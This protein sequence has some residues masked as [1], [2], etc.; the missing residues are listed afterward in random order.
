MTAQMG[1]DFVIVDCE[2]GDIA[3]A[4]MHQS[5]AAIA[6]QGVS[7]VV[8]IAAPE[9][10]L[11]KRALD[12]GGWSSHLAPSISRC[13]INTNSSCTLVSHDVYS[14]M[15]FLIAAIF[16]R[17]SH[18]IQE[19]ARAFVSYTKFPEPLA[20]RRP[21]VISGVRGVGS[22]FAPAA[23]GQSQAEYTATANKNVFIAVQIETV[24]GLNNCE[25]IAKVDGI[26]KS[27]QGLKAPHRFDV[28]CRHVVYRVGTKY[29]NRTVFDS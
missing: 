18:F 25:E 23:L 15:V 24:E 9:N 29:L 8:R 21:G 16:P 28:L 2:H 13:T 11:V 14:S 5:V 19:E 7:P 6:A 27:S 20:N 26:G 1:Y 10:W 4:A 22:P 12:T 3:D 17:F